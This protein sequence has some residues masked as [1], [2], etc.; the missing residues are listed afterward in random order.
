MRAL[1]PSTSRRT[2]ILEANVLPQKRACLTTPAPRFEVGESSVAGAARQTGPTES[3]LRRYRVEQTGYEDRSAAIAAHV[4][5][6]EVHVVALIAQ[7]SSLQTQLTIALGRIEILKAMDPMPQEGP[8][9]TG[10]SC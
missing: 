10:S 9:E 7:T 5:T 4:R 3:N 6:L 8:A 2:D 1:L